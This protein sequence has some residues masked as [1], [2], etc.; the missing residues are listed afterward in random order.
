MNNNECADRPQH[1]KN[2]KKLKRTAPKPQLGAFG[3]VKR[4]KALQIGVMCSRKPI[5]RARARVCV[6]VCVC[7][8]VCGRRGQLVDT[9]ARQPKGL[10]LILFLRLVSE[11]FKCLT[12]L[13][14][15]KRFALCLT[16]LNEWPLKSSPNC[17]TLGTVFL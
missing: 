16:C 6:C 4:K 12:F 5:R 9:P 7:L 13:F 10:M 2:P 8:C 17:E 1:Q 15:R 14:A 11:V 3:Q